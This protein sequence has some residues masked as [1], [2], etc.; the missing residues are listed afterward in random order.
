VNPDALHPLAEVALRAAGEAA[1]FGGVWTLF[2]G[3][4]ALAWRRWVLASVLQRPA[5][6]R[7]DQRDPA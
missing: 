7:S 3:A 1:G 6:D 5:S 4:A 2:A